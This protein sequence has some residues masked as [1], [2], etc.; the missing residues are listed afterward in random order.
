MQQH[1]GLLSTWCCAMHAQNAEAL[2]GYDASMLNKSV[3]NSD[4]RR[5]WPDEDM[6]FA[7]GDCEGMLLSQR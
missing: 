5:M 6:Q 7:C 1:V 2:N 3:H 4:N